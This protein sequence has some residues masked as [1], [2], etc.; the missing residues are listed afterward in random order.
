MP[1]G[2]ELGQLRL[3]AALVIEE[4][5]GPVAPQPVFQELQVC[6]MGRGIGERHLMRTEGAFHR[7]TI[8]HLRPRRPLGRI[9]D[10][11]RPAQTRKVAVDAR[12]LLDC[13]DLFH[14][15]VKGRRHGFVHP[16][17]RR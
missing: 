9:K 6:G 12:R 11:H 8:D 14:R 15:H 5:L 3:E 7:H 2:R 1:L 13:L 17:P 16:G 4:F 10:D